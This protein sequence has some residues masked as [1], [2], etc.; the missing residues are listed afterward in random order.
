MG[1][2]I[3]PNWTLGEQAF[4]LM[5]A[6][7]ET[8]LRVTPAKNG[9]YAD[10]R[11]TYRRGPLSGWNQQGSVK[12]LLVRINFIEGKIKSEFRGSVPATTR[13]GSQ[14]SNIMNYDLHIS[15]DVLPIGEGLHVSAQAHIMPSD[16]RTTRKETESKSEQIQNRSC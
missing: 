6:D 1:H 16:S 7:T 5:A 2:W 13:T 8:V 14:Y 10:V 9:V 4:A 15:S 11:R 12:S 3:R